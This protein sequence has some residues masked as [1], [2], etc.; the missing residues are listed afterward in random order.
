MIWLRTAK[1]LKVT[2]ALATVLAWVVGTNHCLLLLEKHGTLLRPPIALRTPTDRV[3]VLSGR[4]ECF[5]VVRG[6]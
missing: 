1:A 2:V 6:C 3:P 5:P 4:P